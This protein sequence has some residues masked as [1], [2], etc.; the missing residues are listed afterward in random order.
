M[1][2]IGVFGEGGKMSGEERSRDSMKAS[3]E[4]RCLWDLDLRSRRERRRWRSRTMS[5]ESCLGALSGFEFVRKRRIWS[6]WRLS[7]SR[8]SPSVCSNCEMGESAIELPWENQR[9]CGS[10]FSLMSI[11]TPQILASIST[12][13]SLPSDKLNPPLT[14]LVHQAMLHNTRLNVLT[15]HN[16]TPL[17]SVPPPTS[18]RD[19]HAPTTCLPATRLHQLHSTAIVSHV[20][21]NVCQFPLLKSHY[22][23]PLSFNQLPNLLKPFPLFSSHPLTRVSLTLP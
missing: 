11:L 10:F 15:H 21:H 23:P 9:V 4:G 5:M 1:D 16:V 12:L 17:P 13:A 19:N 7:S 8:D 3:R 6:L 22:S 18:V 14:F 20:H 2:F